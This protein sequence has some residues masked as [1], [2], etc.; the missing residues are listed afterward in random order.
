MSYQSDQTCLYLIVSPIRVQMRH[1]L[2]QNKLSN[3]GVIP[4]APGAAA[5]YNSVGREPPPSDPSS[6][7]PAISK[8]TSTAHKSPHSKL[9]LEETAAMFN[10]SEADVE[11]L[12]AMEEAAG[13]PDCA[14]PC[15]L[16]GTGGF[17]FF[18]L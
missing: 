16:P 7:L 8:P 14:L 2:L 3:S 12:R 18:N 9:S 5:S 15:C 4:P 1:A 10:L 13:N 11:E 6:L 17:G